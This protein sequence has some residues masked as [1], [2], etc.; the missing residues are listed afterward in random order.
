[1]QKDFRLGIDAGGTFTDFMLVDGH[2]RLH[3]FKTE[4]TPDDPIRAVRAGFG[5]IAAELG[6]APADL[7]GRA[8]L[9]VNGT[10]IA[11]NTL[12]QHRGALTGLLCTRGHEDSLEIRL[13]QREEGYR[14]NP[15]YPPPVQLVERRLRR[16]VRERMLGDG[17]V[18]VPLNENDV[19]DACG[20][21][22]A[23]G[24]EAVAISFVWASVNPAHERRAAEI[25]RECLPQVYVSV[26]SEILPQIREYTRT[27]TA[28]LNAYLGP[29]VAR[30]VEALERFFAE[31]APG[32]CVRYFQSNGGIAARATIAQRAIYAINSGPAA[33]PIAGLYIARPFGTEDIITVDM[34]GTSFDVTLCR[35]G[36]VNVTKNVDFLRYRVGIPMV[37]V[38][39]LGAGGGSIASVDHFGL[40]CVGPHSAGVQPGP[41]CY[42]RGGEQ[43][44]VTDA[45]LVLGYLNPDFLLGGRLP[46]SAA[47][48]HEV[49]ARELAGPLGVAVTK[50][51]YGVFRLV[52][53]QMAAGIRRVSVEQGL[54]PREFTLVAAG[55]ATG[56]HLAALAEEL[57]VVRVLVPQLASG[58][59]ALGQVLSDLRHTLM[60]AFLA[61]LDADT[62]FL[63]MEWLFEDLAEQGIR[64]L[65]EE[66]VARERIRLERTVDL[67]YVGQVH[68]CTVALGELDLGSEGAYRQLRERF[69]ARHEQLFTYCEPDSAVEIV[70]IE[71]TVVG[72]TP[73]L[74]QRPVVGPGGRL[75][76]ASRGTRD[77]ALGHGDDFRVAPAAVWSGPELPSEAVLDGP[78][79]I[80]E[81]TTTV[82]V[83]PG[84]RAC[85]R[86]TGVYELTHDGA[87]GSA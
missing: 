61:R 71:C 59:C 39:T 19:V 54:D 80:E 86:P 81:P 68:E 4:S 28:V 29:C 78:A 26:G 40:L 51:A 82:W 30:Y 74:P 31:Q 1:M 44:T 11:V 72:A 64:T 75:E 5:Q 25:V 65:I 67:R 66:G 43:A 7:L 37:Q 73:P 8:E 55:G 48:A 24:V 10:T 13:G 23:Q 3:L 18:L 15:D 57:G 6:I 2:G 50:A 32:A 56:V 42:D 70:N 62:D 83:P 58:L 27:S 87:G 17:S 46:V 84:W 85:L 9:C 52:N 14:Y 33:A 53:A 60:A 41:A 20:E 49:I 69:D 63:R 47:R 12:I 77:A 21:F 45:N 76:A 22:A 35:G 79:I 38:E 16:P 36:Q 34:G